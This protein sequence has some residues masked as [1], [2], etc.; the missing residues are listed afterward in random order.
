M[1]RNLVKSAGTCR[2]CFNFVVLIKEVDEKQATVQFVAENGQ[3][4]FQPFEVGL[5]LLLYSL[6]L[7]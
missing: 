1:S 3:T 5:F 7:V 2:V 4:T 6:G